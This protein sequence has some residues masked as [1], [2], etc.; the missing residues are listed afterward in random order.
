MSVAL[1]NGCTVEFQRSFEKDTDTR[2]SKQ[3]ICIQMSG[4]DAWALPSSIRPV[5]FANQYSGRVED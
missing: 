5:M 4:C 1:S 2:D 3:T